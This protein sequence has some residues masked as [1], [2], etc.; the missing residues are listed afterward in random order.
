M[1]KEFEPRIDVLAAD[2]FRVGK[3]GKQGR[4]VPALELATAVAEHALGRTIAMVDEA[5]LVQGERSRRSF[6]CC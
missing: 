1:T 6:L 4:D 2:Q 3:L 5:A